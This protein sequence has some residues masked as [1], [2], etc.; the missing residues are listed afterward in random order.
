M[1]GR[2]AGDQAIGIERSFCRSDD[3]LTGFG[4]AGNFISMSTQFRIDARIIGRAPLGLPDTVIRP[5]DAT[6]ELACHDYFRR[7]LRR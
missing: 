5:A 2:H 4:T 6:L 3:P 7:H 1:G